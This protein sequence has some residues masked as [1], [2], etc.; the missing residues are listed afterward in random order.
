MDQFTIRFSVKIVL[1]AASN[2]PHARQPLNFG[3]LLALQVEPLQCQSAFPRPL[4]G[5]S[6]RQELSAFVCV[7]LET[8]KDLRTVLHQRDW[9]YLFIDVDV[10]LNLQSPHGV[11]GLGP[12]SSYF[13]LGIVRI[14]LPSE[15]VLIIVSPREV[16]NSIMT[17]FY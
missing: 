17:W 14:I 8:C 16:E 13:S 11:G 2:Y 9:N 3:Q 6:L 4:V 7:L 5:Q 12:P 15:H 1:S 10:P